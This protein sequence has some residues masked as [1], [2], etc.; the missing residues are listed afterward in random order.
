MIHAKKP[1]PCLHI[2]PYFPAS[3]SVVTFLVSCPNEHTYRCN[4]LQIKACFNLIVIHFKDSNILC[5][6]VIHIAFRSRSLY[7]K[8]V[9]MTRGNFVGGTNTGRRV[10]FSPGTLRSVY[11][12]LKTGPRGCSTT[13]ATI[14]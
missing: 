4:S 12:P 3:S 2:I 14:Y 9:I 5:F 10:L 8:F 1:V 6:C 11:Q 7:I 13:S